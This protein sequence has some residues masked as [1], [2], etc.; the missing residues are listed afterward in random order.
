MP[1][2]PSRGEAGQSAQF[3]DNLGHAAR[4][5]VQALAL[6]PRCTLGGRFTEQAIG[7]IPQFLI[8]VDEVQHQGES[9]EVLLDAFLERLSAIGQGHPVVDVEALPFGGLGGETRQGLVCVEPP[10]APRPLGAAFVGERE[11]RVDFDEEADF[12]ELGCGLASG[13]EVLERR[14]EE[15]GRG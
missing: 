15:N 11:V 13:V 8:G 12:G 9:G 6:D 1:R 14:A 5:Q 10:C 4:Q 2:T 3:R 7:D